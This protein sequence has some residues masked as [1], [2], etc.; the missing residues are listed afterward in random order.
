MSHA[1][2]LKPI[3]PIYLLLVHT[4]TMKACA[5]YTAVVNMELVL[6]FSPRLPLHN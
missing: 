3:S 1:R 6:I 4:L 2:G 5:L